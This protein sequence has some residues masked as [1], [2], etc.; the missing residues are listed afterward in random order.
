MAGIYGIGSVVAALSSRENGP[1]ACLLVTIVMAVFGGS[2]P[3]LPTVREWHMEWLWYM[4]PGVSSE[5]PFPCLVY[6][7][8]RRHKR[9]PTSMVEC[10]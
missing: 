10:G 6:P 8:L 9:S 2:Q 5:F 3:R 1:L 7:P 4:S